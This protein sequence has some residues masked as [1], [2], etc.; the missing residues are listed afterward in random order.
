MLC[1]LSSGTPRYGGSV[2][3]IVERAEYEARLYKEAGV[4]TFFY[5]GIKKMKKDIPNYVLA[6]LHH[7]FPS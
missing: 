3:R 6:W 4:V 2:R 7:T 5:M 1:I